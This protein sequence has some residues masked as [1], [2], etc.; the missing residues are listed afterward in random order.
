MG[1]L[2]F[3]SLQLLFS[4]PE[5]NT[6]IS[7]SC[8]ELICVDRMEFSIINR[9]RMTFGLFLLLYPHVAFDSQQISRTVSVQECY[10][11]SSVQD[12]QMGTC[13]V[14]AKISDCIS[15]E[16]LNY[17][18][19]VHVPVHTVKVPQ[20]HMIVKSS[21]CHSMSFGIDSHTWDCLGVA[22]D[23]SELIDWY[24][25]VL[26]RKLFL[27][28]FSI[29]ICVIYLFIFLRY[30]QLLR[31]LQLNFFVFRWWLFKYDFSRAYHFDISVFKSYYYKR[32]QKKKLSKLRMIIS[33]DGLPDYSAFRILLLFLV[34]IFLWYSGLF[35]SELFLL[36]HTFSP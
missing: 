16:R 4:V 14:E 9:V 7:W 30:F 11:F 31:L 10:L 22:F 24:A 15:C 23:C 1:K 35:L 18:E 8:Y 32:V 29:T 28:L 5:S 3:D 27:I 2:L 34:I 25:K 26:E 20:S 33:K 36:I 6:A 12:H 19:T 17:S 21:C 13:C